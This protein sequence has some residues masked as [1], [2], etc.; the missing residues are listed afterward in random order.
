MRYYGFLASG[1]R[2]IEPFHPTGVPSLRPRGR[3]GAGY[4]AT[5]ARLSSMPQGGGAFSEAHLPQIPDE[6]TIVKSAQFNKDYAADA[7]RMNPIR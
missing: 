1:C 4:A 3:D 6:S 5:W 7:R 2:L